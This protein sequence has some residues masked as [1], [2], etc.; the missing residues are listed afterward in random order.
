MGNYRLICMITRREKYLFGAIV[1]TSTLDCVLIPNS[2]DVFDDD[3]GH[4]FSLAV[5]LLG[6]RFFSLYPISY[7]VVS[8]LWRLENSQAKAY[9]ETP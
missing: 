1:I 3:K 4:G 6:G 7:W 5:Q 9:P 2:P 8:F